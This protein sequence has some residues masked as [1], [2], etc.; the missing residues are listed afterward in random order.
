MKTTTASNTSSSTPSPK[1]GVR[2]SRKPGLGSLVSGIPEI[3]LGIGFFI[4]WWQPDRLGIEWVSF[5]LELMLL[6]F[7]LIHSSGFM[8]LKAKRAETFWA[9]VGWFTGIGA[10]YSMFVLGFCLSLD[11]WRPMLAFWIITLQR[12]AADVLDPKPSEET[13]SWFGISVASNVMLYMGGV[14]LTIVL[15]I[16]RWGITRAMQSAVGIDGSGLWQDEPH[17][18]VVLAG[19]YYLLRGWMTAAAWPRTVTPAA[20][21]TSSR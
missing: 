21:N 9:R 11:T 7:I 4:T 16:P 1:A 3:A 15:P 6:E 2:Y 12:L 5:A 10:F 14:F 13:Q 8:G 18:V 19:F 20:F 17:R